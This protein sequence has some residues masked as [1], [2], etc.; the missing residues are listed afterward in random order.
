M[1]NN[2]EYIELEAIVIKDFNSKFEASK[3]YLIEDAMRLVYDLY[4]SNGRTEIEAV[5]YAA[6]VP[7]VLLLHMSKYPKCAGYLI[8]QAKRIAEL[9]GLAESYATIKGIVS[10]NKE[11]NKIQDPPVLNA[12]ELMSIRSRVNAIGRP[13]VKKIH[14]VNKSHSFKSKMIE[15]ECFGF[16]ALI[17]YAQGTG[18]SLTIMEFAK[19]YFT[20]TVLGITTGGVLGIPLYEYVDEDYIQEKIKRYILDLI[21]FETGYYPKYTL[22]SIVVKPLCH[23]SLIMDIVYD[24][25]ESDDFLQWYRN[26]QKDLMSFW[27]ELN[28]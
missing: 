16:A 12:A 28:L 21:S 19:K 27:N 17:W 22:S 4:K 1:N 2:Q 3:P 5:N 6:Y 20:K 18:F 10:P 11:Q 14:D 24:T 23:P 8:S 7:R 26:C 13:F 25:N 15:F 9:A